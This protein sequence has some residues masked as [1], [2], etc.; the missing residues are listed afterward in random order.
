M[1]IS[2]GEDRDLIEITIKRPQLF[3]SAETGRQMDTSELVFYQTIPRQLP[4]GVSEKSLKDDA[5]DIARVLNSMAYI[6]I[7]LQFM[8][9]GI[10]ADLMVTFYC[11]QIC[12]FFTIYKVNVPGNSEIYIDEFRKLIDMDAVKPDNIL[13]QF[14][15]KWSVDYFMNLSKQ[16]VSSAVESS[17]MKSTSFVKN[18]STFLFIGAGCLGGLVV[19]ALC[20]VLKSRFQA[21]I[22]EKLNG[23]LNKMFFNGQIKGMTVSYLKTTIAFSASV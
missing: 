12:C 20:T 17:G 13:K 18:M 1:M 2:R 23:T 21:M 4:K 6:Q 10:M 9:K 8:L 5:E 19:M 15:K 11:L 16:R 22:K 14:N 3:K 7:G